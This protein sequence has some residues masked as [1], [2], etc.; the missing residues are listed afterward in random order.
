MDGP[1][2]NKTLLLISNSSDDKV[3]VVIVL[4]QYLD[5]VRRVTELTDGKT[6]YRLTT[7]DGDD[8]N[9]AHGTFAVN[10]YVVVTDIGNQAKCSTS[11][12]L[13]RSPPPS[14]RLPVCPT[15]AAP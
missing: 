1:S 11:P 5:T 9:I 7:H 8:Q 4:D 2:V 10:D 13:R 15:A 3:D 14:A 12:P 6:E